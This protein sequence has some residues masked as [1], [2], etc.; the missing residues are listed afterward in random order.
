MGFCFVQITDHHLTDSETEFVKGYS[1]RYALRAVLQHIAQNVADQADF[2][3]STGDLVDRPSPASY[4]AALEFLHARN[5]CSEMPGPLFISTQGLMDYPMYLL[6][7]NHD[8]RESFIQCLFPESRPAPLMNVAFMHK[9][10]QFVCLDWGPH[11]KATAHPETLEFLAQSLKSGL[12]SILMMHYAVV[13]IGARWLDAFL[14]D[15]VARFWD[16]VNGQN[17]LGI[18]C[19]HLHISYEQ[20]VRGIPVFGLRATAFSFALQDEPL[21]TLLPPHYRLV[22][23]EDGGLSTQIFE[24][25][26]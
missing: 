22:M 10:V 8:D 18:F 24:V 16:A 12:P 14:A 6:P 25:A 4:Q 1:T 21:A 19:G 13:P 17:V 11:T 9:G 7:G 2:L 5:K 3:F 26:L 20:V 23:V 15:D